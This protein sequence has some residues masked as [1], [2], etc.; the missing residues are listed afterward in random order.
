MSHIVPI[1][2]ARLRGNPGKRKLRPG[3]QPSRTELVPEPLPFLSEYAKEE[4][5]RV[6]PELH[7]LG[8]LTPLDHT[9]FGAYCNAY[10][11]WRTAVEVLARLASNDPIMSGLLVRN[12]DGTP[13]RNP[14]IKVAKDAARDMSTFAGHFG[15]T[16]VARTRLGAAGWTPEP[17]SK[18]DGLLG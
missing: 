11:Q 14:L 3:P 13:R 8:L 2:L 1:E 7:V 4:W 18:F 10:S 17:P 5:Q 12:V 6:A 9:A 15:L 16:P